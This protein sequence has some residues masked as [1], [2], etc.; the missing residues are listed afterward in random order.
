MLPQESRGMTGPVIAGGL[1]QGDRLMLSVEPVQGSARP[2]TRMMLD[3][4]L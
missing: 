1:R 4:R 2:T 3:I